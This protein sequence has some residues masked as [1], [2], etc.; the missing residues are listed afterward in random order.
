MRSE[1]YILTFFVLTILLI[2]ADKPIWFQALRIDG[3][4]GIEEIGDAY[5]HTK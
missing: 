4:I 1:W 3:I 2:S 5:I